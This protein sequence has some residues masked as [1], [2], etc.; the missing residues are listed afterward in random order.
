MCELL[1]VRVHRV[2]LLSERSD[3]FEDAYRRQLIDDPS[4]K[5][6]NIAYCAADRLLGSSAIATL[7]EC[8]LLDELVADF[9]TF[10]LRFRD[11]AEP[12]EPY[13]M[14]R[15]KQPTFGRS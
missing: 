15:S 7:N 11:S 4:N 9:G 3:F 12:G 13:L 1:N 14:K 8:S 10:S 6:P 5:R 2:D